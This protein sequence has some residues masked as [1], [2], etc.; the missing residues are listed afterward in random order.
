MGIGETF[1]EAFAKAL[2]AAGETLP[3]GGKAFV[4]VKTSD[5]PFVGAVGRELRDLGFE[6]SATRGTARALREAGV[7]CRVVNKVTEGRPDVTDMM[8]N[9]KIA[10]IVNTTEGRQSIADSSVIR[11]LAL[12]HKVCYTTTLAGGEAFCIAMRHGEVNRVRR[13]QDLHAATVRGPQGAPS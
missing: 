9:E 5:R 2:L 8:K 1:A 10:L 7:S 12:L 3:K 11:K 6:I 4:S 13:L